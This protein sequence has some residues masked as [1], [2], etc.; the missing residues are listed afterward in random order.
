MIPFLGNYII[1]NIVAGSVTLIPVSPVG[2]YLAPQYITFVILAAIVVA[3]LTWWYLNPLRRMNAMKFGIIFG[4]SGYII[5]LL[6]ALVST[7]AG[8]VEQSGSLVQVASG[9]AE[10]GPSVWGWFSLFTFASG[11]FR[12]RSSGAPCN[13]FKSGRRRLSL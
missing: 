9:L 1:N 7:L 5:S 3:L 8:I 13:F 6:T 4:V 12:Q 2:G 11:W 10:V